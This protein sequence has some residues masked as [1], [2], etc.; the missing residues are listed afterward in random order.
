MK[1]RNAL[2]ATLAVSACSKPTEDA[3]PTPTALVRLA[4]AE[5]GAVRETVTL[6]GAAENAVGGN[7]VLSA[8]AEAIVEAVDAPVGTAVRVG[9]VVVRLRSSATVQLDLARASSDARVAQLALA[10]AGRLRGDGLVGNAEVESAR[11]AAA[12]A[13]AT[14]ASLTRRSGSLI[15][16]APVSGYVQTIANSPGDLV[17]AGAAVATIVRAGDLRGRFG[18]DPA[19][20]RRIP[21]GATLRVTPS[22]GTTPIAAPVLS[23]DPVVDPQTRLA[24]V[25]VRLPGAAGIGAGETLSGEL[26]VSPPGDALTIPYGALLDEAGQPF[27]FVVA[28][29]AAHRRDVAVA[30]GDGQR[31]QVTKGLRPGELVVTQ[32]GTAL[33]DGMKVRTK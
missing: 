7:A 26:R 19:L 9:Q 3:A 25:Y 6:Y 29:G 22:G 21:A 17:A 33:E 11:A 2:A 28:R 32:G 30:P 13:Q 8:P 27:V 10:R 16:R 31:V 24:S 14:L 23:V 12:T 15:L 20:A 4:P 1:L 18:V 5:R